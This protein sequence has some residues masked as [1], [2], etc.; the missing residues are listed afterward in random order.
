MPRNLEAEQYDVKVRLSRK[1]LRTPHAHRI[2]CDM[3]QTDIDALD[4]RLAEP[5]GTKVAGQELQ[6]AEVRRNEVVNVLLAC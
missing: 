6:Q 5:R 2:E 3:Y 4:I 1:R